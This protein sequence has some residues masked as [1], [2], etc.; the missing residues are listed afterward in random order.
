[1]ES[2]AT[3]FYQ[4]LYTSGEVENMHEVIDTVPRKLTY[5]MQVLL[6]APYSAE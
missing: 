1:M 5:D 2:M 3:Q 4:E 6:D